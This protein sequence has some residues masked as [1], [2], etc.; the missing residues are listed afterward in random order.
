MQ[1]IEASERGCLLRVEVRPGSVKQ[2]ITI[3]N[4]PLVIHVRLKQHA[5]RGKA[6]KEL[7]KLFRK[8]FRGHPVLLVAGA[9]STQKTLEI[10]GIDVQNVQQI[11]AEIT[12]FD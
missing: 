1:V 7:I 10:E 2:K 4:N 8:I 6:N 11:L 9:K 5:E 12:S 3:H